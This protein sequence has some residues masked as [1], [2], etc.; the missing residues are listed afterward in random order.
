MLLNATDEDGMNSAMTDVFGV[1]GTGIE[2]IPP[3]QVM[4][5][6]SYEF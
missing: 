2:L 6:V 5:R 3:R 1:A 4:G